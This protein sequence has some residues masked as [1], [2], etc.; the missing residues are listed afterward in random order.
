VVS[1][2]EFV[3]RTTKRIDW[4]IFE[5]I[6]S[7][8]SQIRVRVFDGEEER[9]MREERSL[10]RWKRNEKV[11]KTGPESF[12]ITLN[13]VG[14][15]PIHFSHVLDRVIWILMDPDQSNASDAFWRSGSI[16]H[17]GLGFLPVGFRVSSGF[18]EFLA[19]CAHYL[20]TWTPGMLWF[21]CNFL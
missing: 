1:D 18:L 12:Y 7:G 10:R 2:S 14:L 3:F 9:T 20:A 19:T 5:R 21:S 6:L 4:S 11:S 15:D 17:V 8:L 13:R 16:N